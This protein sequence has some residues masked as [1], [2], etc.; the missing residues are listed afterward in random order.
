MVLILGFIGVSGGGVGV[1]RKSLRIVRL[2]FLFNS[3]S[4]WD[5]A[6][7]LLRDVRVVS[8]VC[9]FLVSYIYFRVKEF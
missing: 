9:F 4:L 7:K 5:G 6:F 1:G 3:L 2:V 8:Y